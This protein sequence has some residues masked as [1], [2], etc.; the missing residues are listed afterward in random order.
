MVL[1][2]KALTTPKQFL[3]R[4]GCSECLRH[5]PSLDMFYAPLG[6]FAITSSNS[7][8]SARPKSYDLVVN[9]YSN[10]PFNKSIEGLLPLICEL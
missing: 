9:T 7:L 8:L 5:H 2:R 4:M 6:G 1:Q 10:S 3:L